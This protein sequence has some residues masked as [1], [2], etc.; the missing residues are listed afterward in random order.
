M[1]IHKSLVR[2][3]LFYISKDD[4]ERAHRIAMETGKIAQKV[5][6]LRGYAKKLLVERDPRLESDLAG[7]HFPNP[8]GLAAGWDKYGENIVLYSDLGFGYVEMGTITMEKQPGNDRPRMSRQVE[9]SS[10]G[11]RM[12]FNNPGSE[13]A[14]ETIARNGVIPIPFG[15]NLGASKV[16][17]LNDVDAVINDYKTTFERTT[18][19]YKGDNLYVVA[20]FS[21][22][23]TKDL[24]SIQGDLG[25]LSTILGAIQEANAS[26]NYPVFL[27]IGPDLIEKYIQHGV[28]PVSLDNKLTGI[29]ATNT[30]PTKTHN[31]RARKIVKYVGRDPILDQGAGL[32]GGPVRAISTE[33]VR[34]I[35]EHAGDELVVIGVGGID[36]PEAA[37]EKI[38]NGASLV[39][40]LSALPYEGISLPYQINVGLLDRLEKGGF[41]NI[42]EAVG[43]A[44]S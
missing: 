18:G 21:S 37:W 27:K 34:I 8:V 40:I 41:N 35:Y 20:N 24:R 5:P 44:H 19:A 1:N 12:G 29:I 32:S 10:L 6:P 16:T 17:D 3:I 33:V 31:G 2:P 39:Q 28:I 4:P 13:E 38:E 15:I 43:S 7:L 14:A 36:G 11:N 25:K 26:T 30:I 9:H 22:P 42:Q 23:N